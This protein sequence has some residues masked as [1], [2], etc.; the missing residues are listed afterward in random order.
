LQRCY[1]L[2]SSLL[3]DCG[4]TMWGLVAMERAIAT[5]REFDLDKHRWD[6]LMKKLLRVAEREHR[7][8]PA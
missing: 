8:V 7:L 2:L 3:D 1:N 6:G 5:L 4:P